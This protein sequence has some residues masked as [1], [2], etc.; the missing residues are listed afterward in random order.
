MD[1]LAQ[2]EQVRLENSRCLIQPLTIENHQHIADIVISDK[3]LLQYSPS[4]AHTPALFIDYVETAL[5]GKHNLSRFPFIIYDKE[6]EAYAGTSSYGAI[7]PQHKRLEIGWTWIGKDFQGTGLNRSMKY[8]MLNYAFN[9]LEMERVEFTRRCKKP[10][11]MYG[12]RKNWCYSRRNPQKPHAFAGWIPERY[13]LLQ[14]SQ[15]RMGNHSTK[16]LC[17]YSGSLS[18][19]QKLKTPLHAVAIFSYTTSFM[20]F[21][22]R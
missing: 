14:H 22:Y 9:T 18:I 17:K 15:I 11:I 3:A 19:L 1:L 20:F 16:T 12:F 10:P 4:E 7:V 6:K 13:F 8:L 5:K 21:L 2:L